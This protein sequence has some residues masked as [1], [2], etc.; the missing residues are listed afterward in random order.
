MAWVDDCMQWIVVWEQ[1]LNL[2]TYVFFVFFKFF[3][4]F[5]NNSCLFVSVFLCIWLLFGSQLRY[6]GSSLHHVV[7]S[8]GAHTL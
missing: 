2:R 4:F 5:F 7:P 3:F 6:A 1:A 8:A